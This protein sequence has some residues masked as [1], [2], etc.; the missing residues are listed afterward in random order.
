M[1]HAIDIK[2]RQFNKL[3]QFHKF[4]FIGN[5]S[6][7][8]VASPNEQ[9]HLLPNSIL[10]SQAATKELSIARIHADKSVTRQLKSL[11]IKPG[12]IVN[13]ISKTSNGSV[14]VSLDNKLIGIG[15][16]IARKIVAIPN[17]RG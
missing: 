15:A 11:Q 8:S 6:T 3:K 16:E 5:S 2:N 14:I 10:L 7:K 12:A 9:L 1:T 17:N 13:L 4:I